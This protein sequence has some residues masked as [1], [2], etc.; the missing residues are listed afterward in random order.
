MTNGRATRRS[1]QERYGIALLATSAAFV[2]TAALLALVDEP[3]YAPLIGAVLLSVWLGGVGPA[4]VSLV[5]GWILALWVIVEPRD[6]LWFG[7]TVDMTQWGV[8]LAAGA[9]IVVVAAALR[10]SR[11]RATEAAIEAESSLGRLEALQALSAELA[12][13]VSSA[14]V[15]RA[16]AERA[17]S[18]LDAQGATLALLERDDVLLVDPIGIAARV[19][20]PR[21]R[22]SLEDRTVLTAAVHESRLVRADDRE[23]LEREFPDSAEVLPEIVRSVVAVP[24][25]VAGKPLG[26][27]EF[28]FER[29]HAVDDELAALASTAAGLAELSLER[30][31]LY[32]RERDLRTALDR[33]LQVAPRFFADTAEEVT[34]VI[35][36][37]ARTTFGADYGVLWRIR[38]DVLELVRSD[39][40]R[41]EW[42][43][44]L[45]VS[46]ADFPGL[47]R[48]VE[49]LGVSFVPDVLLEARGGGLERVR[50]LGIRSSLRS[51]IAIG[52]RAEH[53]LVVSWQTV[54]DE[55][56]QAAVAA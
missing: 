32:E 53:V 38:D 56:D 25:R 18:L 5:I 24:L 17:S 1:A 26:V 46:L 22:V 19:H 10:I 28:L 6:S 4:A 50:Q 15:S 31:R 48:A 43:Q 20:V 54:V 2:A 41:E 40:D 8:N 37:E 14:D 21:R 30:A 55:P 23:T 33:I 27:V 9:L 42:P 49:T 44:G 12:G 16:L 29:P 13:A 11:E 34:S 39:P 7:G 3:I 35:C 36:R 47:E 51:P 52:G 45:P